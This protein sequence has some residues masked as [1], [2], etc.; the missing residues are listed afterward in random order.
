MYGYPEEREER[1][2]RIQ[3]S[4]DGEFSEVENGDNMMTIGVDVALSESVNNKA[5][6]GL[7]EAALGQAIADERYEEAAALKKDIDKIKT[8]MNKDFAK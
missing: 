4:F 6:L 1:F 2:K 5:I 7:K 3:E 8:K